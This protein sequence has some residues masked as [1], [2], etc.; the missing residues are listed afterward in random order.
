MANSYPINKRENKKFVINNRFFLKN[1]AITNYNTFG[2]GIVVINLL[3]LKTKILDEE[4]LVDYF[5]ENQQ[6][7]T[8]HHSIS[9]IPQQNFWYKMLKLKIKKKYQ[10]DIQT[11]DKHNKKF[12]VV[13]IKDASVEHFSIYSLKL[14]NSKKEL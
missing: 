2:E 10:I 9:Y 8:I 7:Q 6:E 13:F 5:T 12:L 1:Y 4:N 11:E 14:E 3:L